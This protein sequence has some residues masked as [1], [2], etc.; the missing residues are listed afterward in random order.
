MITYLNNLVNRFNSLKYYLLGVNVLLVSGLILF[1]NGGYFPLKNIGDFLFFVFITFLLAL[2][3]PGWGFLFFTGTIVLEN[4]NLAPID[5]GVAVRPYQLIGLLTFLAIVI[6][7][8]TN[9]LNFSLPKF[10]WADYVLFLLGA[11]G[12]L[13]VLNA[14]SGAVAFKQSLIILSFILLYL[15]TRVFIQKLEDLKKIIPFFLSSSA[16]VLLYGIW[17]NFQF[18]RGGESFAVMPGRANATFSEPDWWGIFLVFLVAVLIVL[19][20]NLAEKIKVFGLKNGKS[21]LTY[22]V[23]VWILIFLSGVNLI[24]AVSRSAWLG[25]MAVLGVF[26]F[27]LALKKKLYPVGIVFSAFLLSIGAV[28]FFKLTNFELDNRIQS[29]ASGL[30]EITIACESEVEIPG[31]IASVDELKNYNCRHINLEDVVVEFEKGKIIKKAYRQDPNFNIR[32][33][34]YQKVSNELQKNWFLGIGWG[35]ISQILGQDERGAGLN[36]SNIFL[37]VWLGAGFLGFIAFSILI[38]YAIGRGKL[39]FWKK[40]KA[41]KFKR[42]DAGMDFFYLFLL[43]SSLAVV[44]PNLFNAGIMLGFLWWWLAISQI[45]N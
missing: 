39:F 21:F 41:G 4:I 11:G 10:I 5:L 1:S 17:Q 37:E 25:A 24:I 26:G 40:F 32:K 7:Y 20:Y 3:R 15:L 29:T 9:R 19:I 34:I 44:V 27:Y 38:G 43:L 33:K 42:G 30:Q 28:Y 2:Y 13:A 35:N 14:G 22:A 18:M 16:I 8:L 12:F 45:K 6:R 36:S 31:S 23:F